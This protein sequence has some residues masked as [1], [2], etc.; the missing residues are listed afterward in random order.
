M[1]EY[2]DIEPASVAQVRR[3][4]GGHLVLIEEDVQDIARDLQR[5]DPSLFLFFS[6]D[7]EF[8]V[9]MQKV[10][11][12]EQLVT[13][14]RDL[15]RRLVDRVRQ[16]CSPGYDLIGELERLEAQ[17]ERDADHARRES[18][19]DG[20]ERLAHALRKDLGLDNSRAFIKGK[21]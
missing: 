6:P 5:I 16:V 9:V 10:G 19:G 12:E 21:E 3:G 8:W 11:D 18:L 17:A 7:E 13:T 4:L 1:R 15:D 14:T 2:V 20:A